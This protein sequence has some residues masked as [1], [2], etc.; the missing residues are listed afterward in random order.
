ML[1]FTQSNFKAEVEQS[2]IP[3]LVDFWATWCAPCMKLMPVVEELAQKYNGKM[4]FGKVNVENAPQIAQKFGI[5]S[6]PTLLIFKNGKIMAQI[7]GA[8]P[9]KNIEE[10]ILEVI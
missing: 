10:K 4:K 1:E 9:K 5:R 3:V 8:Q 7:I 2:E 6:I